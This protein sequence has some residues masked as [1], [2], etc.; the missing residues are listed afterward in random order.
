MHSEHFELKL[1]CSSINRRSIVYST[2]L[3]LER[4][5]NQIK[6][7]AKAESD[8]GQRKKEERKK[9][10]TI[11]DACDSQPQIVLRHSLVLLKLFALWLKFFFTHY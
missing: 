2:S 8:L 6:L 9:E 4:A 3:Q 10:K 1:N 11:P 5:S 7:D